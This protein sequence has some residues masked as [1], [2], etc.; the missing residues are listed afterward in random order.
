MAVT[1]KSLDD[2][3]RECNRFLQRVRVARA[4]LRG[5]LRG[6]NKRWEQIDREAG[7]QHHPLQEESF[8]HGCAATGAARRASLDLTRVLADFRK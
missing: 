5:E 7:R 8:S 2:V 6:H 1:I 4:V 3:E